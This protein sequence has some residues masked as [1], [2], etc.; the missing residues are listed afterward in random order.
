MKLSNIFV[1]DSVHL[2]L[3]TGTGL[4]DLTAAGF[5][6]S[7]DEVIAAGITEA[8]LAPFLAA[9]PRVEN[10][11]YAN[12]LN[13]PDKILCVGL[14]YREHVEKTWDTVHQQPVLFSKFSNALNRCGGEVSLPA[15]EETYDYEAELVIV[16]GKETWNVS[17]E[18]AIDSVFGY[19]CGNDLSCRKAQKRSGQWLIGKSLPGFAP[20]GPC[21]VTKD[22]FDP[23]AGKQVQSYVNGE[24]RQNGNTRQMIF[25]LR[26]IISYASRYVRLEPGDLIFTGTPSGTAMEAPEGQNRWLVKGDR[27]DVVIEDLGTLT[28]TFR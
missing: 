17:E 22:S 5:G 10:P 24:L 15:W 27:V 11:V 12:I 13:K 20:A 16:I 19:T 9:A 7:M 26:R 6:K 28:S 1:N 4:A 23:F 25:D 18:D 3:E 2:A 14:N 21:I 8:E